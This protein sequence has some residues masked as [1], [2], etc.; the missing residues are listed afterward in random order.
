[1]MRRDGAQPMGSLEQ[2]LGS[3]DRWVDRAER[4]PY[5]TKDRIAAA[6]RAWHRRTG[7]PP[8]TSD[9]T[10]ARRAPRGGWIGELH[11]SR[12]SMQHVYRV[13]AS[14]TEAL[15]Y[16]GLP[17]HAKTG[18][19]KVEKVRCA[20][21]TCGG[22]FEVYPS[23]ARRGARFCSRDCFEN[24]PFCKRGH[25]LRGPDADVRISKGKR[26]C[27]TCDRLR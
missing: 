16:A 23:D 20:C 9:W 1:M 4:Q 2:R 6:M 8:S 14:W 12:P 27:R 3:L 19:P 22:S 18:R 7:T 26:H 11:K 15:D 24:R 5:W 21:E 10:K 13:F 25:P 17:S